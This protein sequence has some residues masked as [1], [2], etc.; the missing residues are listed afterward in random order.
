MG[1]RVIIVESAAKTRTIG[2]FLGDDFVLA[3][4]LGHVRDLPERDLGV[5]VDRG[6]EPTYQ[7]MKDKAEVV[8]RLK[9]AVK[10]AEAVF[11][12]TDPDREGEAIAWHLQQALGLRQ[13][14]RIEFNEI[15]RSA[16]Q[17]ALRHPRPIDL[18]RVNAQQA[19]RILDR[20]VGYKLSPLLWRKVK[21]ARSAGRVQSIAVRLIVERER[22]IR[23]FVPVEHWRVV[24]VVS[25]AD[26]PAERFEAR[27]D[28]V[29]GQKLEIGDLPDEA[30]A[31]AVVQELQAADWLVAGLSTRTTTRRAA[32]PLITSTLQRDASNKLGFRAQRTMSVAQRLY[33]GLPLGGGESVGLITYM[34]TDSTR[35]ANE[36]AAAAQQ[37][38]S[39]TWGDDYTGKGTRGK[40]P[41]LAQDAHECIRPTYVEKHPDEI[42]KLLPGRE[43]L[44][45]RRLYRLIWTRFVASQM[46][47]AQLETTSADLS[48]GPHGLRASGT[49]VLFPGYMALTGLPQAAKKSDEPADDEERGD[50]DFGRLLPPLREGE[51]LQLHELTPSQH[52][53]QPPPR[54][55][56]ASLVKTLEER[57]IGRPSTYAPILGTIT[58]RRYVS[59][60]Q[61]RFVPTGLGEAVNDALVK[62]FP[63]IMD[64]DFT[65]TLE[66]ELDD[67]ETGKH[68]WVALLEEFHT[69]FAQQIEDANRDMERV[70]VQAVETDH[71]C[72]QCGAKMLLREGRYG[73]FLGCSRYP[74]CNGILRLDRQGNPVSPEGTPTEQPCPV[75]E[76]PLHRIEGRWGPYLRC[77]RHPECEGRMKLDRQGNATA[78]EKPQTTKQKCPKCSSVMLLRNS[79]RGPFLGCSAYPKC[80]GI[81]RL[82]DTI[83]AA[84]QAD[85]LTIPEAPPSTP[86]SGP[87]QTPVACEACGSPMILRTSRRGPFLGCS[88]YPKC[89]STRELDDAVRATLAAAGIALDP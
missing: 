26:R 40:A 62:H 9:G 74:E 5:D 39:E 86:G 42:D 15:T 69:P 67:V 79:K 27:L 78:V 34:R 16:V 20:L 37:L 47:P 11:L 35:V 25:P 70:K 33:E 14:E 87:V 58:E 66:S 88:G 45:A 44:D 60:E 19:R 30:A 81:V 2:G 61:N 49:R 3:A 54:Y 63:T 22:E 8:K 50:D 32:P 4:S 17:E 28:R 48:A 80:R 73:Q 83:R 36:A 18:D 56:E 23:D 84:L 59:L 12:A 89:R 71:D 46:A 41:K 6:F 31:Q 43:N 10:G 82:D 72:P 55:T 76:S 64:V 65:A 53:T 77:S 52:V 24:A 7:V 21:N 75:C 57:G 13:V 51:P 38:I 68:D 29:R 1:K 85:G